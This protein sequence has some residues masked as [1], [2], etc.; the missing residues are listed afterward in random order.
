MATLILRRDGPAAWQLAEAATGADVGGIRYDHAGDGNHYRTWLLVDG[1]AR[2]FGEPLPQLAM[3][4][5]AIEAAVA[6]LKP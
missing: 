3:A 6:R 4:A 1:E 2:D 5:R